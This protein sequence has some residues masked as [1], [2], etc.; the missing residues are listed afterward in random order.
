MPAHSSGKYHIK[1]TQLASLPA[2][3]WESYVTVQDKKIYVAG[4]L[5]PVDDA[6][7]QIYVYDVNT[8]LWGQL[9][10]SGRYCDVPHTIG[11]KLVIIGG[12]LSATKKDLEPIK[13]PRL[14]KVVNLRHFIILQLGV[15]QGWLLT[16]ILLLL[17]EE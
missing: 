5:S 13:S 9:P 15:D 2:P 3:M 17:L 11:G 7:H 6:L 4:A 8:D 1:W 10:P 14:M 16:L 12:C